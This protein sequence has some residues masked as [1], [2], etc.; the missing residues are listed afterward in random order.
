MVISEQELQ[1]SLEK[2]EQRRQHAR[3]LRRRQLLK[4][5]LAVLAVL[6]VLGATVLGVVAGAGSTPPPGVLAVTWP[7]G[8]NAGAL[9]AQHVTDGTSLLVKSGQPLKVSL[10]DASKW[11]AQWTT[12]DVS[13]GGPSFDWTPSGD[14]AK[15][16]ATL[17]A[18]LTGWKKLLAWRWPSSNVTL[19]GVAGKAPTAAPATGFL[20]EIS[21][22]EAGVWMHYRV[23][24]KRAEVRYDDRAVKAF[25]ETA[26]RMALPTAD[27]ATADT[28]VWQLIPAFEGDK[29]LPGDIGTYAKLKSENPL[30]DAKTAFKELDRLAPKAT[31]KVIV[32]EGT[33]GT[34]RFRLSFDDKGKRYVWVHK[35]GAT[36]ATPQDWL[37]N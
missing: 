21:A 12:P 14:G 2:T 19:H 22:P 20:H 32:A 23:L 16:T 11:D 15:L 4:G 37:S 13:N 36:K 25:G 35:A 29:P 18:R 33:P 27:A 26:G 5:A 1:A 7:H 34:A 24:A 9:N 8:E 17:R 6:I 3:E 10:P 30:A 28:E 31:I